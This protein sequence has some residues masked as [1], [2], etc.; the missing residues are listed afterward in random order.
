M[1]VEGAKFGYRYELIDLVKPSAANVGK[2]YAG[3]DEP[4]EVHRITYAAA[5]G[6]EIGAYLT[7]PRGRE[8]H[9]LPLIVLPHGGPAAHDTG[10]FD[11]WSQALADQATR[12]CSQIIAD[13]M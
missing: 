5:D 10:L 11:W 13:R 2:A 1:L 3:I 12:C 9:K 4:L 8:R 7:L 6:L